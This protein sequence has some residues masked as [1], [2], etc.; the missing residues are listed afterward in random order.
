MVKAVTPVVKR[1]AG[2][3]AEEI[4]FGRITPGASDDLD[5]V[6]MI[7]CFILFDT[8]AFMYGERDRL[9]SNARALPTKSTARVL[10]V[11]LFCE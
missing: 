9:R 8:W 2:R 1:R 6:L 11:I 10:C 7:F 4:V 3:V 5:R